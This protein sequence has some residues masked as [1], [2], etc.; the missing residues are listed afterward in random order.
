M[1]TDPSPPFIL[2]GEEPDPA[3][4]PRPA[5]WLFHLFFRPKSFFAAFPTLVTGYSTAYAAFAVGVGSVVERISSKVS[6]E[7]LTGRERLPRQLLESWTVYWVACV[8]LGILGALLYYRIGGWW[9]RV[10]LRWSGACD[11]DPRLAR[12]VYVFASL[13]VGL[14]LVISSLLDSLRYPTPLAAESGDA[15]WFWIVVFLTLP[16]WSVYTSYRGV[17]TLFNVRTARARVWFLVLPSLVYGAMIIVF[18]GVFVAA[19]LGLLNV[20]AAV[21][22]PLKLDRPAFSLSYPGNWYIDTDDEDYDPDSSF[23]IE[24]VQDALAIF[25]IMDEPADPAELTASELENYVDVFVGEDPIPFERWGSHRGVGAAF[26]GT[27]EG[28]R[29][30]VRIFSMSTETRSMVVFE[31]TDLAV[32]SAVT[33]GFGLLRDTFRFKD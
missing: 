23:T 8:V 19:G 1:R 32:E 27:Y 2:P 12:Q 11:A 17:R 7:Q 26:V 9:Y 5:F 21:S 24:P 16:F 18:A 20:P 25:T 22:M 33:P 31:L 4:S 13:I 3:P 30:R 10:R 14:P 6:Q 28:T 15:S 29:Y